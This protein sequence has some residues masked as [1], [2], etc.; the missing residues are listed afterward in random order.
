MVDGCKKRER[1]KQ[2]VRISPPPTLDEE[3]S[4]STHIEVEKI[5]TAAFL[6]ILENYVVASQLARHT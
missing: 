2:D 1:P 4:F 5:G 6:T 3:K